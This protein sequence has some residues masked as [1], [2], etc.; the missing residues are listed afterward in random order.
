MRVFI[1]VFNLFLLAFAQVAVAPLFPVGAAI[2]DLVLIG[3]M[4]LAL[5]EGPHPAMV[6]IPILALIMGFASDRSAAMLLFAY[7]PVLPLAFFLETSGLPLNRYA[8]ASLTAV[9]GG[10]L[11]RLFLSL[12][13]LTS[14]A[15]FSIGGL[16]KDLLLPGAFLDWA[17]LSVAFIP[18]RFLGREASRL[19]LSRSSY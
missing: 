17:L 9:V 7:L 2:P 10:M 3:I 1:Y 6:A 11:A 8:Q 12:G 14:G 15:A 16:T 4:A 13:P 5:Y 18:L 19:T